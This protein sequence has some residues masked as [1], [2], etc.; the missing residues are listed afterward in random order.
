MLAF[1]IINFKP[2]CLVRFSPLS[3]PQLPLSDLKKEQKKVVPL[4]R[5]S[6][7]KPQ[8]TA[9][10]DYVNLVPKVLSFIVEARLILFGW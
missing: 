1:L 8:A 4:S 3:G 2:G 9:H 7:S 6:Q 5:N 10:A